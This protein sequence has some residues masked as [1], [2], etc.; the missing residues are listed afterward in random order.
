MKS[1]RNSVAIDMHRITFDDVCIPENEN[2]S[3]RADFV[4][5]NVR[6]AVRNRILF[7]VRD[8]IADLAKRETQKGTDR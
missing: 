1:L 6:Q 7:V 2:F 5:S 4:E 8:D 3:T